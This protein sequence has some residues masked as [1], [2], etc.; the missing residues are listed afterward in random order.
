[1]RLQVRDRAQAGVKK[2]L[3]HCHPGSRLGWG[4]GSA[5]PDGAPCCQTWAY[6]RQ[7]ACDLGSPVK[8][9]PRQAGPGGAMSPCPWEG[10]SC[11]V[12]LP[13]ISRLGQ[14]VDT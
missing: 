3:G 8:V 12:V 2:G 13:L 9:V 5:Q 1:M 11:E 4:Q 7:E 6:W 10:G 14:E